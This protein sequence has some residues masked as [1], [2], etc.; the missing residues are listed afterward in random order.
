[1]EE[2]ILELIRKVYNRNYVGKLKVNKLPNGYQVI[3]G[4]NNI[5]KPL[6]ISADLE[7]DDFLKFFEQELRDRHLHYSHYS[8]GYRVYSNC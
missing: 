3:L 6:T 7:D 8:E 1:M 5:D 4:L 2:K